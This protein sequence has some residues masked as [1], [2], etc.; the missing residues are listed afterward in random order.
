MNRDG[1]LDRTA[2]GVSGAA[3]GAAVGAAAGAAAPAAAGAVATG[4]AEPPDV[5][6]T[7][8][9]GAVNADGAA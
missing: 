8:A 5:D 1:I 3:V 7:R 6:R 2:D 4:R 9:S